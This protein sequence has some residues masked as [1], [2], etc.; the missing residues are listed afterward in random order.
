MT[1]HRNQFR[2]HKAKLPLPAPTTSYPITKTSF[3]GQMAQYSVPFKPPF[4]RVRVRGS[5]TFDRQ[6]ASTSADST[7]LA[8]EENSSQE[9]SRAAEL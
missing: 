3:A 6:L 8:P 7:G 1:P 4:S 9:S 2:I 5:F